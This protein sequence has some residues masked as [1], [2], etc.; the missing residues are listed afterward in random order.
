MVGWLECMEEKSD[1]TFRKQARKE[2]CILFFMQLKGGTKSPL[3]F[4]NSGP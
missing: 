4:M 3:L 1:K 2:V